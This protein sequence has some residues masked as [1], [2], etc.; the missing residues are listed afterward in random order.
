MAALA[1]GLAIVTTR[2]RAAITTLVDGENILLVPPDDALATAD[3]VER[4]ITTPELRTRLAHGALD[5]AQ[6]FTWDSIA[7][8]TAQLYRELIDL[9]DSGQ[10]RG[11]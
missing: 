9:P 4:L 3:A 1:H 7:A 10:D 6:N 11:A 5:L 8:K 2:P